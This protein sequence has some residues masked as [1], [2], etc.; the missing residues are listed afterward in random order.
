MNLGLGILIFLSVIAAMLALKSIVFRKHENQVSAIKKRLNYVK[1]YADEKQEV[2]TDLWRN[3]SLST[4]PLL[5]RLLA[6]LPKLSDLQVLVA[7]AGAPINIGTIVLTSFVLIFFAIMASLVMRQARL[8]LVLAPMAG[9]LPI[10]W[11]KMKKKGRMK[12]LEAQFP[13]AVTMMARALRAGHALPSAMGMIASEM[14]DP[15]AGE[16]KKTVEDYSYGMAMPDALV[17]LVERIGQKDVKFFVTAVLLQRETGGNLAEILD[18]MGTIILERFRIVRQVKTLSAEGRLSGTILSS[19]P[20]ILMAVMWI[21]TPGYAETLF[22][23]PTGRTLLGIGT[24]CQ[25]LG[26]LTIKKLI[27]LDV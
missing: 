19:M 1:D 25:I 14:D 18:N 3:K 8:I 5:D 24:T 17:G 4:I 10:M 23:D 22:N 21:V 15:I 7:Q 27:K 6:K 11:L 26:I 20:P 13:E 2:K 12:K 16:F 9:Y